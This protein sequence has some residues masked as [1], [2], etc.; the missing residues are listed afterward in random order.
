MSTSSIPALLVQYTARKTSL[1][2]WPQPGKE[3]HQNVDGTVVITIHDE[4]TILV[5][6]AIHT[7]PQGHILHLFAPATHFCRI[8]L[9]DSVQFFPSEQTLVGEHLHKAREAPIII[10]QAVPNVSLAFLFGGLILFPAC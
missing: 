6:A 5:C 7:L 8:A 10:H 9:I 1:R 2:V 3:P 4:S